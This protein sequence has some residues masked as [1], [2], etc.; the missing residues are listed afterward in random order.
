[1]IRILLFSLT[2][3]LLTNGLLAQTRP[4]PST[5]D[6]NT[7]KP[8][9]IPSPDKLKALGASDEEIKELMLFKKRRLAEDKKNITPKNKKIRDL[10]NNNGLKKTSVDSNKTK[11]KSAS[12][13]KN[14]IFGHSF[15]NNNNIK[16]Y[17]K[18]NQLKAPDNY[19]LGVGDNLSIAIWGFSDF[20]ES[21]TIGDDGAIN[22]RLVG[23]IYLNGLSFKN[24]K[25]LIE[26]KFSRV[27]NLKNS[28]ID[29]LLT[30]SRVITI[31]V[32]GEVNNPGGYTIPAIN[33]AFN[34][35]VTVGG[36][37]PIGSVRNIYL[38]RAGKTIKRLDVYQYLTNPDSKQ[39]FF[40]KNNDYLLI[41]SAERIVKIKGQVKRPAQYEL[42]KGENLESLVKYAGGFSAG[43]YRSHIQVK[44][45]LNDREVIIDVNYDSLLINNK[46]FDLLDGDEI[47]VHKIE[48]EFINFVKLV[49]PVTIPGKYEIKEGEKLLDII[50]RAGGVLHDVYSNR[51]YIIR[52]N[53]DMTK[54]YISFDLEDLLKN[55]LSKYNYY[56]QKFDVIKIFSKKY[57][58]D[59]FT[60][61]VKGAV[62]KPGKYP[63]GEG[64]TLKDALYLAGKLKKE[65]SRTRI[66]I[67]RAIDFDFNTK[68][69]QPTRILIK[70]IEIGEDFMLDKK[71]DAF[72][73]QP[74]DQIIVRTDPAFELQKNIIIQGEVSYPGSYT[75][76]NK[77][78]KI[79]SI[80]ERAGGITPWG[81]PEGASLIRS[82]YNAGLLVLKLDKVLRDTNS[83]YNYIL[84]DGDTLTIPKVNE[85]IKIA[86]HVQYPNL[87]SL[88]HLNAPFTPNKS[89]KYYIK[90]FALGFKKDAKRSKTYVK[91]AGGKIKRTHKLLFFKIYPQVPKGSN[92]IVVKKDKKKAKNREKS[93]PID[94]NKAIENGTVKL[95]AILTLFLL[96]QQIK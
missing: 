61:S 56:L 90:N 51:A 42:I 85:L 87:D 29:V 22:P 80:I 1:M 13:A 40:L 17:D 38:K 60:F 44:R 69:F 39:N 19:I 46:K 64:V 33:T 6:T 53:D 78:E 20:N 18:A 70:T 62:R 52:E 48:Q 84:R 14:D 8:E 55:K 89:A 47:S 5:I 16:F 25:L 57:F 34:A 24:A 95:T 43:A 31:N 36:I 50:N 91:L 26:S 49:G 68:N 15:F 4:L 3:I 58:R 88:K 71:L 10:K 66:E 9:N 28:Q 45:Y 37:K 73:I 82:E 72:V 96:I 30:Y 75:L 27:Y 32:V 76:L 67:S 92:I 65:A 83:I 81:F 12:T 86:G 2:F 77:E 7:V 63:F 21:F 79:S 59:E 35:L 23:K 93:E 94:W 74:F 41:P 11:P 54:R